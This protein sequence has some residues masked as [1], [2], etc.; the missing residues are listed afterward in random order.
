M[1]KVEGA[2][3]MD[4]PKE[5]DTRPSPARGDNLLVEVGLG[6]ATHDSKR[7]RLQAG[8]FRHQIAGGQT[9]FQRLIGRRRHGFVFECR[10]ES[11]DPDILGYQ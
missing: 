6:E 11:A 8:R 1:T 4:S 2:V 5:L 3:R 7:F 10:R 9:V